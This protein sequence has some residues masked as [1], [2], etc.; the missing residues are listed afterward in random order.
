MFPTALQRAIRV[1]EE[2]GSLDA[3]LHRWAE[4]YQTA[5]VNSLETINAWLPKIGFF[6]IAGY[7]VYRMVSVYSGVMQQYDS[8][9]NFS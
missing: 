2:T 1:G 8:I 7:L 5:A 9:L 6:L 4:Y 3:D